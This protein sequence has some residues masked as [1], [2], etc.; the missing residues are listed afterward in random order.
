MSSAVTFP[1]YDVG[2]GE[3]P[4]ASRIAVPQSPSATRAFG[5]IPT[6]CPSTVR[7]PIADP[8][9]SP[10][11]AP[12]LARDWTAPLIPVAWTSPPKSVSELTSAAA[13]AVAVWP[14]LADAEATEPPQETTSA[15]G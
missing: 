8:V 4:C 5:A 12:T 3:L 10:D 9:N 13:F 7:L 15:L 11:A 6:A 1:R 2:A 14:G